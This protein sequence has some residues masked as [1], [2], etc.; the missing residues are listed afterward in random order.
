L[1]E[2]LGDEAAL[3]GREVRLGSG[4]SLGRTLRCRA[5]GDVE[6]AIWF[7]PP[8]P[9]S[10][11]HAEALFE[12]FEQALLSA[13]PGA[14]ESFL[15]AAARFHQRFVRLHPFRCAN[16]SLAHALL[17]VLFER[18]GRGPMPHLLLDHFAL[19]L[20]EAAYARLFVRAADVF[21][22]GVAEPAAVWREQALRTTKATAFVT[23]CGRAGD[24]AA[25]HSLLASDS[26]GAQAALVAD[27]S[28]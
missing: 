10:L 2:S 5:L 20:D 11:A 24:A 14:G 7:L 21:N 18:A 6:E 27:L 12:A 13:V 22:L 25:C 16:Q 8:R 17:G 28:G 3:A 23:A 1:V 26:A 19:R 15:S 9:L 4:A